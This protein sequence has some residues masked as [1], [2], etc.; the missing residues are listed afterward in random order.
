M[1]STPAVSPF[2][3]FRIPPE[4]CLF[5]VKHSRYSH[6]QLAPAREALALVHTIAD[7]FAAE[8][9]TLRG[10]NVTDQQWGRFLDGRV[11]GV[12]V[13]RVRDGKVSET[14]AYVKR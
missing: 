2:A 6:A 10:T 12:D 4:A 9:G 5:K 7:D 1:T 14:F 3:G 8:V 11:R 13:I